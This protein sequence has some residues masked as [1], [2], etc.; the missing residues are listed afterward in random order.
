MM[1]CQEIQYFAM[2]HTT[3]QINGLP[4]ILITSL[5]QDFMLNST[6]TNISNRF[7]RRTIVACFLT[8]CNCNL[9]HRVKPVKHID[10]RLDVTK[11]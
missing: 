9:K 4:E 11:N 8:K 3:V 6:F 1:L 7:S 10:A 2:A 5:E